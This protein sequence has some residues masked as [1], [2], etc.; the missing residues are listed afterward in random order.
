MRYLVCGSREYAR[1]NYVKCFLDSINPDDEIIVGDARGVDTYVKKYCQN[2]LKKEPRV[3]QAAW[4]IHGK[5]A[6]LVRNLEMLDTLPHY[7]IAFWDGSSPGTKFMIDTCLR[8]Q[9]NL[10]VI[11]DI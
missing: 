1:L 5:K 8:R 11:F 4:D 10:Q 7:V 9:I 6:G 2:V 3:Y